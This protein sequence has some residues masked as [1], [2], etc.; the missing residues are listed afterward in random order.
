MGRFIEAWGACAHPYRVGGRTDR[1]NLDG[2]ALVNS[3][4]PEPLTWFAI[5]GTYHALG[6]LIVA[7]IVAI[8]R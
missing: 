7:I 4:K 1:V 3:T 8:W 2:G 5:N 6:I